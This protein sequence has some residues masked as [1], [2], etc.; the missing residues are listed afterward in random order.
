[1]IAS[2]AH[3]AAL[4]AKPRTRP[5]RIQAIVNPA[6]GGVGPGAADR[7]AAIIADRGLDLT[8][9]TPE[10]RD[11]SAAVRS[12]AG[13]AP[14][15]LL[16][17]AGD[18]TARLAAEA[19]GPEGPLV[20]PLPGGT[21]NMLPHAL[22]G[23]LAWPEALEAILDHGVEETVGGG[24]VGGHA[25]Y[26]AA[27]LGPPALWGQAREA[28]RAGKIQRA[29]RRA[30]YALRRAFTGAIDVELDGD[31]RRQMEALILIS[32]RVSRAMSEEIALEAATL[33][34]RSA[35]ET[36][37]LLLNGLVRDWRMDPAVN[38][39]PARRGRVRASHAIPCILDGEMRWL[40]HKVEFEF[41]PRAFRALAL[42]DAAPAGL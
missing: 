23:A 22:Y 21:L 3:D 36:L 9:R 15:L 4:P 26:V 25:F 14:D 37:R 2:A 13:E 30:R 24:R 34:V 35:P 20:A 28:V 27:I 29:L 18:G 10:P 1:M 7:L 32:P 31:A 38:V 11:I 33:E 5:R 39:V 42:P 16:V 12:A 17:L 40:R 19:C 6:S 8:V 41:R